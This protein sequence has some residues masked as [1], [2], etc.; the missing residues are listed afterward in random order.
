ME[1]TYV[2][3]GHLS[4]PDGKG[5]TIHVAGTAVYVTHPS[6]HTV[7][8]SGTRAAS[9]IEDATGR[10]APP[11]VTAEKDV[12]PVTKAHVRAKK[13]NGKTARAVAKVATAISTITSAVT[14][15]LGVFGEEMAAGM[16]AEKKSAAKK[17]APAKARAKKRKPAMIGTAEDEMAYLVG[18]APPSASHPK[19][20]KGRPQTIEEYMG[21]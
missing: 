20:A 7:D 16:A 9:Y 21:F 10:K 5:G 19:R 11:S 1:W 6:K 8:I 13:S 12:A 15:R 18:G 3:R 17:N 4:R 14:D 2:A